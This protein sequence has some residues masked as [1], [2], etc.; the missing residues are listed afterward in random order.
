MYVG[1]NASLLSNLIMIVVRLNGAVVAAA[2]AVL[3]VAA[4]RSQLHRVRAIIETSKTINRIRV[5][6]QRGHRI[7]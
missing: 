6:F 5:V 1:I 2:A 3:M 7:D 4:K